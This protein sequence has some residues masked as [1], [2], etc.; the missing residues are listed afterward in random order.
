M[1]HRATIISLNLLSLAGCA[2][3]FTTPARIGHLGGPT[4]AVSGQAIQLEVWTEGGSD[5]SYSHPA[6]SL[7]V[8]EASRR[9]RVRA[10]LQKSVVLG[11]GSAMM[12]QPH[13]LLGASFTPTATGT[14]HVQAVNF[15]AP[16]YARQLPATR[17]ATLDIEVDSPA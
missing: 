15:Y 5:G 2:W 6:L 11:G 9:V 4:H 1:N 10:T 3:A 7:E 14:W 8:D 16:D 12:V 13:V 17:S